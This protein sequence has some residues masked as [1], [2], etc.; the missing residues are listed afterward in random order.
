M[1][2]VISFSP[3]GS[4]IASGSSDNIVRV[5]DRVNVQP[6]P[7]PQSINSDPSAFSLHR[8]TLYPTQESRIIPTNVCNARLI[9]FSS[10]LEHALPNPVDLLEPTSHHDSNSAPFLLRPDGWVMGPN[11]QLLFW[12]PPASRNR[13]YF[14]GTVMV[15]PRAGVELDLSHMAH[16][17]RWSSCRDAST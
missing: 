4:R 7:S 11:Y 17:T 8:S 5:W 9:S 3:D 1:G 2:L 15:I 16:G 14:P 6:S 10:N 12:V 13:F